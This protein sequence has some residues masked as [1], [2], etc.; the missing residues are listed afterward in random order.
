MTEEFLVRSCSLTVTQ[1]H[2]FARVNK[3]QC[4]T[5]LQLADRSILLAT[6][7]LRPELRIARGAVGGKGYTHFTHALHQ[8]AAA[9]SLAVRMGHHD[10]GVFQQRSQSSHY[11]R[12]MADSMAGLAPSA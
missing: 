8:A 6:L 1:E 10:E 3:G 4:V 11:Q 12:R 7:I 9:D 5:R 2:Q